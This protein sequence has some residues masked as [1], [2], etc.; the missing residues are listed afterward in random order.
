MALS[1]Y[2]STLPAGFGANGTNATWVW[3]STQKLAVIPG[4][5]NRTRE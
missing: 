2:L 5:F 3:Y 4:S 1:T